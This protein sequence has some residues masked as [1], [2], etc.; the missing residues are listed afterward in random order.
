MYP[1]II[2]HALPSYFLYLLSFIAHIIL[3]SILG[4]VLKKNRRE[5]TRSEGEMKSLMITEIRLARGSVPRAKKS[6]AANSAAVCRKL[7]A[8]RLPQAHGNILRLLLP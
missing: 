8:R 3:S 1:I 7:A 6:V 4:V 2:C 5:N